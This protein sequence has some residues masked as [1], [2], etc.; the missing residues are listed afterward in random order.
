MT[1]RAGVA[2]LAVPMICN[3]PRQFFTG[4]AGLRCWPI[5]VLARHIVPLPPDGA[6]GNS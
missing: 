5:A 1:W 4:I 2:A 3:R 6:P